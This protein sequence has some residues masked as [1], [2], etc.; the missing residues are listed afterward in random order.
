MFNLATTR[1]EQQIAATRYKQDLLQAYLDRMSELLL[2]KNLRTSQPNSEVRNVARVRTITILFQL[3]ARRI[4]YVFAFLR[5]FGLMSIKSD[6]TIVSLSGA[7]LDNV[8]WS[9]A[10]LGEADLGEANLGEANLNGADLSRADLSDVVITEDQLKTAKSL[11]GVT[12][13]DGSEH[14]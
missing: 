9:Q 14:S 2:E 10:N 7:A 12:M 8:N 6:D 4:G 3:D 11:A 13:P 5:E 1:T